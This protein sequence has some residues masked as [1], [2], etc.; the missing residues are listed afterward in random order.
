MKSKN[1]IRVL[2]ATLGILLV[3]FVA[4]QF[5]NEVVWT[6]GDFVVAGV[7]IFI[8]GMLVDLAMRKMGRHKIVG[9][10]VIFVLFAWLWAELAVGVFTN[11]GN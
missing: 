6:S 11:W 1:I 2:L 5:T 3:P 4:M 10:L 7:M 8:A 9:I